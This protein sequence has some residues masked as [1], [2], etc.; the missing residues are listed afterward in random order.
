MRGCTCHGL[1]L[2]SQCATLAARAGVIP[3][4][5]DSSRQLSEAVFQA[6]VIELAKQHGWLCWH[7]YSAKKSAAGYPDLTLAKAGYPL[8]CAE[9]KTDTGQLTRAQQA[10]LAAIEG[11]TGVVSAVWRPAQWSE[12]VERLRG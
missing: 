9:L 6:A 12:I 10:W 5:L 3:P 11:S 2:C 1:A 7:A 4:L 8:I